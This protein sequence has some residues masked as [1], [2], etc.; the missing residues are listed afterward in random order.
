MLYIN[1]KIKSII[2]FNI[3]SGEP[4]KRSLKWIIC[5]NFSKNDFTLNFTLKV[6]LTYTLTYIQTLFYGNVNV[7]EC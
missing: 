1:K 4:N 6:N 7:I 2:H 3:Y 5:I